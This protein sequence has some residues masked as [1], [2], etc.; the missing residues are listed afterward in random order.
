MKEKLHYWLDGVLHSYGQIFFSQ[1]KGLAALVIG[2]SLLFPR[3]GLW[4]LAGA[5]LT[6]ALAWLLGFDRRAIR[7][8]LLGFNS[9]LVSLGLA[10]YYQTNAQFLLIFVSA[11]LLTL[12][13]SVALMH[14]FGAKELPFLS[15]PFLLV[16]W[17]LLLSIRQYEALIV[18]EGAIFLL[19]RLFT[20]GGT[21][22]LDWYDYLNHL[23]IPEMISTY[24]KSLAA[25]IFQGN[26]L[27]GVLIAVGLFLSSRIAFSLTVLGYLAGYSFYLFVGADIT[28]LHYMYIGFNFILSAIAIGGFFFIPS[29]KSYLLV[30]VTA[31]VIAVMTAAF[32]GL[33]QGIQLPIYSL[34]FALIVPLVM[35]I[36]PLATDRQHLALVKYQQYIPERNLY[37]YRNYMQRF[38]HK[39]WYHILLPFFG[40]W[41]VSQGHDGRYTHREEWRHAWDFVIE[42]E[43]GKQYQEPGGNREDYYCYQLPIVAPQA[44]YVVELQD[45]TPENEIGEVN[46]QQNWGNTIVIK[47]A[48]GLYSKLSH[49]LT[50]SFKVKV[51]DYVEKGQTLALLG[52]SG[53]SPYPHL[54]FQL[55]ATPDI[56]SKTLK[57]PIAYYLRQEGEGYELVEFDYPK[58]GE[59]V[60]NVK[61][62]PLLQKAFQWTPG[63]LIE[64]ELE[65]HGETRKLQWEVFTDAH[66]QSYLYCHDTGSYAYFSNDGV[67]N[68]FTDFKG[69]YESVLYW[70]Y[71]ASYKVLLGYYQQVELNDQIPLYQVERGA[72]RYLQDLVAPFFQFKSVHY[73]LRYVGRNDNMRPTEIALRTEL[74]KHN[75]RR[76]KDFLTADMVIG[77]RGFKKVAIQAPNRQMTLRQM[78]NPEVKEALPA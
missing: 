8:G 19:N 42:D 76:V 72:S 64:W 73:S 37:A 63:R 48:D 1:N 33:L 65:E 54:H 59:T 51:G 15:W 9:V 17:G 60:F 36:M 66:N 27:A 12:F 5:I 29:W 34:P 75:G 70:F 78:A 20:L 53:R 25:I 69:D 67:L 16:L 71:L 35:Y 30:V 45:K 62:T 22:L 28:Q 4:G 32:S 50:G 74:H 18:S 56:G 57:F 61:P 21:E 58:E 44:G 52:N 68:Y 55:Q 26:L 31:P 40:E 23:A 11:C 38:G 13:V 2:A 7:D 47:H 39:T 49:L 41:T 10:A 46:L 6:N 24:F 3:L 43:D 77:V 14:Y